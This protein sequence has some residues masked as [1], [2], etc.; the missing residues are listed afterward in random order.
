MPWLSSPLRQRRA[1]VS[2]L[3]NGLHGF[4]PGKTGR[5]PFPESLNS[6]PSHEVKGVGGW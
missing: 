2:D 3:G 1:T 4:G 6:L 5:N